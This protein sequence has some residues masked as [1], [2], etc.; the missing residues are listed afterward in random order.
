MLLLIIIG[1]QLLKLIQIMTMFKLTL[2]NQENIIDYIYL[3]RNK[4]LGLHIKPETLGLVI[5]LLFLCQ[6]VQQEKEII[7]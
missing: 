2:L 1:E 5:H 4:L 7:Q 3:L 6:L